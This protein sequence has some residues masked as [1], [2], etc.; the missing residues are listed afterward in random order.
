[1][2]IRRR[3]IGEIAWLLPEG[4]KHDC[5]STVTALLHDDFVQ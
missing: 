1:M 5:C 3:F 2:S 4:L